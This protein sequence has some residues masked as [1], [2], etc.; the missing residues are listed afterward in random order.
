MKHFIIYI[1]VLLIGCACGQ[2]QPE[3]R[4]GDLLFQVGAESAMSEAIATAT[5]SGK[6]LNFT[7]VGIA[8][9]GD[10][11]DS[12][13][14]A[15]PEGGVRISP[16]EEFLQQAARN[17]EG[18]PQVVAM[19]LRD[20]A[21]LAAS[22]RRAGTCVGLPYDY[23]FGPDNGKY[24][25]SELVW[26]SYRTPDSVRRFTARPMN[27]RAPDGTMPRF[28]IELFEQ[29]GEPIPEGVPG[30]NPNDMARDPQLQEVGRWF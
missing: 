2:R 8:I 17:G 13:L 3:L 15:V 26:E 25:C 19:R 28:W 18:L 7:H 24:Y 1:G 21:G 22:V 5:E 9:I 20:T 10:G 23:A 14:E 4:N 29:L 27:F 12:V 16:L 6:P 11:A 30:T